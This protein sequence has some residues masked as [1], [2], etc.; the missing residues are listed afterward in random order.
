VRQ[1][2]WTRARGEER[3][4]RRVVEVAG[5]MRELKEGKRKVWAPGQERPPPVKRTSEG[6]TRV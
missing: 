1:D 5:W 4:A 3:A 2:T 6:T